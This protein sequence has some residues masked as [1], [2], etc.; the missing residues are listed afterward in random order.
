LNNTRHFDYIIAGSGCAG[1]SLA[2][3]LIKSG[4]FNAKKILLI[5][6]EIKNRNDRTWCFWEK[7]PGMF[8][9]VVFKEWQQL[10]LHSGAISR[11]LQIRPYTYKLIKGI[12]F[13][14]Y[15]L[16]VI[17]QQPN[18]TFLQS[19]VN[20]MESNSNETFIVADGQKFSAE[21]IFNSILPDKPKLLPHQYW[22][23]QHFKG[24]WI[25]TGK[26]AFDPLVATLMDF[27]TDQSKGTTF[28]YVLPFSD[29]EALVEYTLFSKDLL[30]DD[31]YE[32]ALKNYVEEQANI[33]D[34][35]ITE[36][37]YGIIPMTNYIFPARQ[38]NIINIGTA[39][40]QTRASSGYTFSFIQ[41]QSAAIVK[42][43][44]TTGRP[45][46]NKSNKRFHF[47]DSTLLNIL[48]FNKMEGAKIFT[49]LFSQNKAPDVLK[50]LDNETTIREE[51]KIISSLTGGL[52]LKSAL[53]QLPPLI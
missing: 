34:Y 24:W 7:E 45:S 12:D 4:K 25:K 33:R 50:F 8:Q 11:Q 19:P 44:A 2:M 42:S 32:A 47:Y 18:I 20:A 13:Y 43:L 51:L 23:Q 40:G 39:G 6:K 28:F 5:D 35:T 26:P 21:Y 48:Y 49:R 30:G 15:C 3:H 22:L 29:H 31:E 14:T 36:K 16:K 37:E 9:P 41:K 10:W 17:Q 46:V 52:F 1:L 27:R 53:Q 38:N